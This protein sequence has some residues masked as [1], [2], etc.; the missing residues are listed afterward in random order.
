M[1]HPTQLP[2]AAIPLAILLIGSLARWLPQSP[3]C[4]SRP[5]PRACSL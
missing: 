1:R 3:P 5:P 4:S 2:L